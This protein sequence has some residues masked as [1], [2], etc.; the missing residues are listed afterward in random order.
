[1]GLMEASALHYKQ[2]LKIERE[3][4]KADGSEVKFKIS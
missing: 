4:L 1:M 2:D 3:M